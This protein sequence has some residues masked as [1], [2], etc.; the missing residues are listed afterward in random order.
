[1]YL[2]IQTILVI[3]SVI[4]IVSLG[5]NLINFSPQEGTENQNK[6]NKVISF[7]GQ[8]TVENVFIRTAKC[9]YF[10]N[11]A[12]FWC[13]FLEEYPNCPNLTYERYINVFVIKNAIAFA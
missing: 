12:I 5:Q 8:C 7:L 1:M 10:P 9:S 4:I 11:M 13:K 2:K 3:C 6:N